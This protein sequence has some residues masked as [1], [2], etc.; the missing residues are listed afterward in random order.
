VK[1]R[2]VVPKKTLIGSWG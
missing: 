2:C 1:Q